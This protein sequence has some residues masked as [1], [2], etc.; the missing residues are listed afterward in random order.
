MRSG[1]LT[2]DSAALASGCRRRG[3]WGCF[4]TTN[5]WRKSHACAGPSTSFVSPNDSRIRTSTR[6]T[7]AVLTRKPSAPLNIN[8]CHLYSTCIL[9]G[10][11]PPWAT[12]EFSFF[13]R[14]LRDSTPHFVRP[15]VT[16]Y[17]FWVFG[18]FGFTAPAQMI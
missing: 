13:S 4:P 5:S 10:F 17:F 7:C 8:I 14:V 12:S 15:S 16:L 18:I 2:R 11:P 6:V 1:L 9:N 3:I